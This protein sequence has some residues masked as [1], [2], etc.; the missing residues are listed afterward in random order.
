[1]RKQDYY[2]FGFGD[3]CLAAPGESTHNQELLAGV[4]GVAKMHYFAGALKK[5]RLTDPIMPSSLIQ[6]GGSEGQTQLPDGGSADV[7][8]DGGL[9]EV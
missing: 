4:A 6:P 9:T 3:V 7:T 8:V 2:I 5:T 1:M